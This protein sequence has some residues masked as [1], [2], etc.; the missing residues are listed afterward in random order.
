MGGSAVAPS[1]AALAGV[2]AVVWAGYGGEEAGSAL[3]DV[4]L[5]SYSPAG[6]MP[7]TSYASAAH[8][9]P[10][11][12]MSM[13]G[14][15]FGRTYRYFTG[16]QPTFA[17]GE[18]LSYT[19]FAYSSLTAQPLSAGGTLPP[20]QPLHVSVRLANVGARDGDEVVALYVRLLGVNASSSSS[21]SSSSGRLTP[22][23]NLAAFQRTPTIAG[24]P[25]M[26]VNF[27]LQPRDMAIVNAELLA[28][29]Q[30]PALLQVFVGTAQPKEGDW[31]GAQA[32][33]V[34]LTGPPTLVNACPQME[35]RPLPLTPTLPPPTPSASSAPKLPLLQPAARPLASVN[36]VQALWNVWAG[37]DGLAAT[38]AAAQAACAGRGF[39]TLRVAGSPF[40]PIE[41]A[42]YKANKTAFFEQARQGME[43][44][45][46]GGCT[47]IIVTLFWNIFALSD[48]HG[49]PLGALT[50]GARGAG[51]STSYAASLAYIDEFVGAFK[52]MPQ[53]AAWELTNEFNLLYDLDQ[54]GS[55]NCCAPS[56]GTPASRT[57]ADNVSTSDGGSLLTAW[58][59][60]IRS[61]DPTRPISSGH[62][63]PRPSA[64]HLRD[65]Y[66]APGRDWTPD[67]L[68]EFYAIFAQVAE[69]C[70]WA[71]AHV[72]PGAD[73]AR[74]NRTG[75]EDARML[76]YLQAATAAAA[77]AQARPTRLLVGE[78]GQLPADG[79][80]P[81][82]PRPFVDALLQALATTQPPGVQGV[83][84][85]ALLW[86]WEFGSQNGTENRGWAVWPGV[87]QGLVDA[88]QAF[89]GGSVSGP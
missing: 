50:A 67:T 40:W 65:S 28:W 31:A 49:E 84:E 83:T 53:V 25:P 6:R 43:A 13:T 89:N 79:V 19:R 23:L 22:L 24:A 4:L 10:Y 86:V 85:A 88:L 14:E 34:Q 76:F 36:L 38:A 82:A 42:T 9:P 27:T 7:F 61:V 21:S 52:A 47:R 72:Y 8:L 46:A 15:P 16:P 64:M 68:P 17:F 77:A 11:A 59:S 75:A 39:T 69:C 32:V 30:V 70:E 18:G 5:G 80:D 73:N 56:K 57:R 37:G 87:T 71:S 3:A 81:A 74:W 51:A 1:S 35:Q 29:Q 55:T 60:R 12:N 63:I 45:V 41:W 20:C 54:S 2:A 78:F 26:L 58:A 44:L 48:L 66:H 62:G 33:Q